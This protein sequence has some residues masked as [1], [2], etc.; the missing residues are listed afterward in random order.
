MSRISEY[1]KFPVIRVQ[2][3]SNSA[4]QGWNSIVEFIRGQISKGARRLAIECYPGVF[5]DELSAMLSER[6][7]P[8]QMM[9]VRNAYKSSRDVATF[10]S[11][12]SGAH[13]IPHA[14]DSASGAG[15]NPSVRQG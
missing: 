15:I 14:R 4:W 13:Q 5:E 1:D 7:K 12:P 8:I 9:R 2:A 6:L 3:E 11:I 10:R